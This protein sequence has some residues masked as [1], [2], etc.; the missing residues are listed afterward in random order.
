MRN[1]L[2]FLVFALAACSPGGH[3]ARPPKGHS[4]GHPTTPAPVT[5]GPAFGSPPVVTPSPDEAPAES[6]RV[7]FA[8]RGGVRHATVS[9]VTPDGRERRVVVSPPWSMTFTVPDGRSVDVR[10]HGTGE[11]TCTLTVDGELVKSATSSGGSADV[12]CGDSLGF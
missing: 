9:Y 3:S 4:A 7:T 2:V 10:A 8:I 6:H 11:L 1:L 12:D 5:G